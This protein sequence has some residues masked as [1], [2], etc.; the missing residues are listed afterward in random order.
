MI[1]R[2]ISPLLTSFPHKAMVK[3]D[4]ANQEGDYM[5]QSVLVLDFG[6]QYK[7]L[8]ARNVRALKVYSE[9]HG[10]TRLAAADV[11]EMSPIGIILTGGPQSA[12]TDE[13]PKC[14]PDIF[15]LG[16]PVLGICYG[17]QLMARALGGDVAPGGAG[18]YG[19]VKTEIAGGALLKGL[20]ETISALMSHSDIVAKAPPGFLTTA[21]TGGTPIAA[22]ED[23]ER[24]LYGV[25]FHPE[26][27]HTEKGR[28][29]LKNFLFGICGAAGDYELNDYIEN[30]VKSIRETVGEKPVLL[31]LSGGVDSSVAA[32]LLSRAVPERLTCVFVDHGLLRKGEGGE[33]ERIFKDQPLNFIRVNAEKKY[34]KKLKGV[35]D[36]ER[37]RKIIGG[38]F[39]K[40][41]AKE[42]RKLGEL[43]FL[44]QGTIYPDVIES[45][46]EHS[47]VIKSHHNVGGLPADLKFIGLIEP[48]SGLFKDEVRE[49]GRRLGLPE[50]LVS[51][52]P[53]PGPGL[54][55]RVIGAVT[56]KK[57]DRLREADAIVREE[58]EQGGVE[59]QQYFAVFPG[60]R[61]VG[62][63]G[64]GRTYDYLIA[65]RAVDT[66]DFM[67]CSYTKVP[68][69]VLERIGARVANEVKGV[70]R[71]VFDI[72]SKP[73]GTVEWE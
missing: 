20:P 73:P 36:P 6:G 64:D 26:T 42:A 45:G 60:V 25:Q 12:Y 19:E 48:L 50:S 18:E 30:A 27:S 34:L 15:R 69:G 46:G 1:K 7:E 40:I 61:S 21:R 54:G 59:S 5:R 8:I 39:P 41:F 62:V 44:A 22:F 57:L 9:I 47:A 72:T 71:V 31:A 23:G 58:L 51:R 35:K 14:D 4:P 55:I 43:G 56:K 65:V 33:V 53:F 24:R 32:A 52:Q 63:M 16:I 10:G 49:L 17:M 13:A 38:L 37:K 70:N 68:H 28:D 67:T 66:T 11:E 2:G 29:I 3:F